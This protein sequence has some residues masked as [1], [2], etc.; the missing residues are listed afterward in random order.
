[1]AD[2]LLKLWEANYNPP[3]IGPLL[4]VVDRYGQF[5]GYK[6]AKVGM[7]TTHGVVT[8]AM[9]ETFWTLRDGS[10]I[11]LFHRVRA[12]SLPVVQLP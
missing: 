5:S 8:R 12:G 4:M 11:E 7:K 2:P 10:G 6:R 9:P 3:G 1:V